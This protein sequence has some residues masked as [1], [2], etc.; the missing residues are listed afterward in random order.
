MRHERQ[1]WRKYAIVLK[2]TLT[3]RGIEYVH[4]LLQSKTVPQNSILLTFISLF[5]LPL[6][7]SLFLSYNT[8][9]TSLKCNVNMIL[10]SLVLSFVWPL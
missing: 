2:H 8:V 6:R 4:I 10:R 9:R 5:S 1:F 7:H 3:E